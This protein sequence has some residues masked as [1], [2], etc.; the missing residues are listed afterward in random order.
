[1]NDV[2]CAHCGQVIGRMVQVEAAPMLEVGG[3]IVYGAHGYCV[4]CGWAFHF[5]TSEKKLEALLAKVRPAAT[6][7]E[8]KSD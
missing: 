3:L 7:L 5:S 1:M 8:P 6:E 4:K 2:T